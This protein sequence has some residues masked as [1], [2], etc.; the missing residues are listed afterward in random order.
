MSSLSDPQATTS[1]STPPLDTPHFAVISDVIHGSIATVIVLKRSDGGNTRSLPPAS[2]R[3]KDV[4]DGLVDY[5]EV[6]GDESKNFKHWRR[7]L[8][9]YLATFVLNPLEYNIDAENCYL[10]LPEGYELLRRKRGPEHT[11]REDSYLY[12]SDTVRYFSSPREFARHC[13]WLMEG[14]SLTRLGKP[15]CNCCHCDKSQRQ[16]DIA[17]LEWGRAPDLRQEVS[18]G[19]GVGGSGRRRQRSR[20]RTRVGRGGNAVPAPTQAKDYTRPVAPPEAQANPY[21]HFASGST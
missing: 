17:A 19:E 16:G 3:E 7:D 21:P 13:K 18:D 10:R 11:P 6:Q 1:S 15:N 8:G 20:S 2:K 4:R 5:Y 14:A 12:G 9:W